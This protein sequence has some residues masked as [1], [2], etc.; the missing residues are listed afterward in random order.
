MVNTLLNADGEDVVISEFAYTYYA[1]GN[2]RTKTET[3]LGG[4]PV[5]TTYVY[6]GLGRLTAETKGED[7]I[8]YTYDAN[9]NRASMNRNGTVTAYAYDANN[10]LLSE[11]VGDTVTTYTYDANGNTLTAGDKTY[12]YNDRGQQTG[13]SNGTTAAAYAYNPSGLRKAK[14]VGGSTKYFVYNGM[15]IVYEYSESVADGIAYFYGLNRTHNSKGEI[16]VYNAHGDVVQLVKDNAVVASYTYDAFGNLTSQIGES[17]NPFLYCGEYFDA[18]TQTYYL[19]ARYYNPANGRFTQ[20]DAWAFMD[21]SDPLS[22]NLYTY[23]CNNPVLYVDP[24]GNFAILATLATIAVGAAIGAVIDAG[25]QLIQNGGNVKGINWRSVG[26]SAAAGAVTTGLAMLTGGVSLGVEATVA[27]GALTGAAGYVTYNTVNGSEVSAAGFASAMAF[28]GLFSGIAYKNSN[29]STNGFISSKAL[30]TT[31]NRRQSFA[32]EYSQSWDRSIT[33]TEQLDSFAFSQLKDNGVIQV[34]RSGSNHPRYSSPNSYYRTP[35]GEH[36]FVYDNQGKLIYDISAKRVKYFIINID[37]KGEE[38]FSPDKL[39]GEVPA[40]LKKYLDGE[41]VLLQYYKSP[42][43]RTVNEKKCLENSWYAFPVKQVIKLAY[44][45]TPNFIVVEDCVFAEDLLLH[46]GERT[47]SSEE[48]LQKVYDLKQMC[49]GD[50]KKMEM[51]VNSWSVFDLLA[52]YGIELEDSSDDSIVEEYAEILLYF[53]Q[54]RVKNLFPD[55]QINVELGYEIMGE[56]G[57]T[58]TVY[59]S[60][61]M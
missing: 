56:L 10:R 24:H 1:D 61:V 22:L 17:D 5:T 18:E 59:Q 33:S 43:S 29:P 19:R 7:S 36:I 27:W 31:S 39:N 53:W 16:Y 42:F 6:D 34:N 57:L 54:L 46:Y 9:G 38:H 14:T 11:T 35:N 21:A 26:A 15:N 12:T 37:P 2:Q 3:L 28:G 52:I 25:A 20:Q 55:R 41:K 44:I 51:T 8:T 45:L 49:D 4:D 60:Q 40:S 23:C 32:A 48:V 47:V 13:Y 30:G 58:I 50:R